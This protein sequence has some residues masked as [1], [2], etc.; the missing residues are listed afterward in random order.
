MIIDIFNWIPGTQTPPK[1]ND[2]E[3]GNFRRIINIQVA[4]NSVQA[5]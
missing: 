5:P 4:H 2:V 3:W 1:L